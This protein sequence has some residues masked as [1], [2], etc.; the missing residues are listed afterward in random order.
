MKTLCWNCRGMG[1]PRTVRSLADMVRYY[2]PQVVGLIETKSEFGRLEVLRRR[3]GFDCGFGVDSMGRSGGLA[4]WW[5]EELSLT[6][7]SYS[8]HHIDCELEVGERVRLTIFYGNP[9]THRRRETWDLLRCLSRDNNLPWVVLGDFNEV[10]FSWEA[11]G[12]RMR[13]EWQMRNFRET[14]EACGLVD[15]GYKGLPYTFSN[16]RPGLLETKARLDRA[17]SNVQWK[18]MFDRYEVSHLITASSDHLPLLVDFRKKINCARYNLFRFEP[19]WLRHDEFRGFLEQCWGRRDRDY[20]DLSLKLKGCGRE[21][22]TWN[23]VV[24]GK[25]QKR[26]ADLKDQIELQKSRFRTDEVIERE[27]KLQRELDEWLAREELLWRQRSRVEWLRE[28]DSN[29]KFFHSRASQRRRKNTVEKIRGNNNEWITDETEIC[30]EAVAHFLNIF[31]PTYHGGIQEWQNSLDLIEG[32]ISSGSADFLSSSFSRME[33]QN[34][35]FQIGS[36]KAPGPDGFSALF[37]QENWDLVKDDVIQYVLRFLNEG[38][39]FN[40]ETNE[41]LIT[42]IPKTRSPTTFDDFRPISLCNVVMKVIT[43][44]L[45]NRLKSVLQECISPCQSAFVPGRLITDNVLIAHELMNFMNSRTN[46]K[47]G[48]CCIKI[49]MSKAY[50]R[51][52]WSFLEE[53]QRRMNFPSPWIDKVMS[54]VRSVTYRIR[55]NGVVSENFSPERGIRQGDPLSPYLFV[56]C[57]EWLA[58]RL[59]RAL[60]L[61]DIQGI[62][63][64]RSAPPVSHLMFA[65]DCILFVKADVDNIMRLKSILKEFE[66]IS[67]QRINY[68]KSEFFVG[69]NVC[70]ELARCIGSILGMK[71][72]NRIEKY[73]GLPVCINGRNSS[74]WNYLEDRMWKRVSGWKEKLLSMAGKETLIKSVVQALPV[75]ALSC[76]RLPKKITDRWNSIVSSFWW[77]NAKE[78]RFI[79]WLDKR[80]LQQTK[81]EG[82]LGM[83]NFQFLNWALIMKQA[84]R[85]F[86]KPELLISKIYKARYSSS[87]E[88]LDARLGFRPSW[89]WRSVHWGLS[90]LKNWLTDAG[91]PSAAHNFLRSDGEFSTKAAYS[92][93]LLEESRKE[94]DVYG[95]PS[96]KSTLKQFWKQLWRVKAQNKAKIFM[97]KLFHNAVPTTANLLRRGCRVDSHCVVCGHRVED[98]VHVFLNCWWAKELWKRLLPSSEF[99]NLSFSSLADWIWFCIGALNGEELSKLFCGSRWIWWNRNRLFHNKGGVDLRV[100]VS[101]IR[102]TTAEFHRAGFRFVCSKHEPGDIWCPPEADCFKISCDGAWDSRSKVA[103]IGIECRDSE[104]IVVFVEAAPLSVQGNS[105]D[106][107]GMALKRGMEL[108]AEK[109]L[110]KVIFVS[111]NAEVIQML[112]SNSCPDR[113]GLWLQGCVDLLESNIHWK[114]EHSLREANRVADCLARKAKDCNWVWNS[115]CAIPFVLSSVLQGGND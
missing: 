52:E 55:V 25:V 24:F 70:P 23:R 51:M 96:D 44:T 42:L 90:K 83:K 64:S 16:R 95:E 11:K 115:S 112:L 102:S 2:K 34:A 82:G 38:V 66:E 103:G 105:I 48:F 33:V 74:M 99:I 31:K 59:E 94:A 85:I 113:R 84:W 67:G 62:Q 36:T 47:A 61:G 7:R 30:E 114:V 100:A 46:N 108:V 63:V 93:L 9:A 3:L 8:S 87:T 60:Q 56:L 89:A 29:T 19:M 79:A 43:K 88:M 109:K 75:Y 106:V 20:Q 110:N 104:G 81:E 10:L 14:I 53:M 111:D 22:A 17:F 49:D 26:I 13:R 65:D 69:C 57:M 21:L 45:A 50:D 73:L 91:E 41:T 27:T 97:W 40:R 54:C 12:R 1:Q 18:T 86:S 77:N 32:S 107:E 98:G 76:F 68:C 37:F 71:K 92:L 78:G 6:L 80:K 15:L 39:D 58:R 28:G 4:I 5:K 35:M 72:V 101:K